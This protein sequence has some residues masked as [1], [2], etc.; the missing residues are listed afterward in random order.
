MTEHNVDD[1]KRAIP[2]SISATNPEMI[3]HMDGAYVDSKGEVRDKY[4]N[5]LIP[6]PDDY[7]A[8]KTYL[9]TNSTRRVAQAKPIYEF[10][11]VL[12]KTQAEVTNFDQAVYCMTFNVFKANLETQKQRFPSVYLYLASRVMSL[13]NMITSGSQ[14]HDIKSYFIATLSSI[15]YCTTD[16]SSAN[17]MLTLGGEV[18]KCIPCGVFVPGKTDPTLKEISIRY[19]NYSS[20][21]NTHSYVPM[22]PGMY[23]STLDNAKISIIGPISPAE[24]SHGKFTEADY[25]DWLN[26]DRALIDDPVFDICGAPATEQVEDFRTTNFEKRHVCDDIAV[27][28]YIIEE[29]SKCHKITTDTISAFYVTYLL[30]IIFLSIKQPG[31]N[32]L[33]AFVGKRFFDHFPLL[34][35]KIPIAVTKY[36]YELVASE[37][38]L[39]RLYVSVLLNY[40]KTFGAMTPIISSLSVLTQWSGC[41][42]IKACFSFFYDGRL[43]VEHSSQLKPEM[44]QLSE[45]ISKALSASVPLGYM[46]IY[47]TEKTRPLINASK[48]R[49]LEQIAIHIMRLDNRQSNYATR[50]SLSGAN[51]NL[52]RMCHLLHYIS[53]AQIF[54]SDETRCLYLSRIANEYKWGMCIHASF[55]K[56]VP[57]DDYKPDAVENKGNE[58]FSQPLQSTNV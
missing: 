35:E 11:N 22:F 45:M 41:T 34:K 37:S 5:L 17:I 7:D 36:L 28:P 50:N 24:S 12:I 18:Y 46:K 14:M 20:Y 38:S 56:L 25:R 3:S 42:G 57:I 6:L 29:L 1:V 13:I 40:N 21:H 58:T 9:K 48:F 54:I 23:S 16:S 52:A 30:F 27:S 49:T 53:K 51:S 47:A 2:N 4:Q 55:D 10:D 31:I 39:Q 19:E 32:R 26:P 15:Y 8:V 33:E 43:P 44:E